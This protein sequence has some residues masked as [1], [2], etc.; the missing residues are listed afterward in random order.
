M[1]RP[2][3]TLETT[4]Y[5]A[6]LGLVGLSVPLGKADASPAENEP[7]LSAALQYLEQVDGKTKDYVAPSQ[8]D[9]AH[10]LMTTVRMFGRPPESVLG[11]L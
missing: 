2:A 4:L 8:L 7:G 11:I 5:L 10:S 9:F 3:T 1:K 6:F